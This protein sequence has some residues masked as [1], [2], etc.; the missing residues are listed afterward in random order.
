MNH[1]QGVTFGCLYDIWSRWCPPLERSRMVMAAASGI[2]VGTVVSLAVSGLLADKVNWESIFYVFGAIGIIWTALW[3]YLVRSSPGTDPFISENERRHIEYTLSTEAKNP[4]TKTPWKS[5]L[6]SSA[7]WAIIVAQFSEAWGMFTLHTQ[8]P[9][10]LNDAL[11][12]DIG[13]SGIVSALPYLAM[14][15]MLNVAGYS[16]DYVQV[17]GF[18]ST[19]NTRRCFNCAAFIGQMACLVFAAYFL[20][21]VTSVVL[22]TI[23][24]SLAAFA[25]AGFSINY[26]EVAPQFS[27]IIM[28]ISN[29]VATVSGIVS[30]ILT[31]FIVQTKVRSVVQLESL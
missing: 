12:Y 3:L 22:I 21:P 25:Y 15:L 10:F 11:D 28:S 27:G 14:A 20:H 23:G 26:L 4:V 24:V 7:V 16:A 13:K 18:L 30:P 2:Q 31:G 1:S 19:R 29:M 9:Q 17:K 6:T 8:L 5:I